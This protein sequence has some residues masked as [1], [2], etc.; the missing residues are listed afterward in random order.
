ML[1]TMKN[2]SV[3]ATP[4]V[5]SFRPQLEALEDRVLMSA[6]DALFTTYHQLF[7]GTPS[8]NTLIKDF[9]NAGVGGLTVVNSPAYV[10]SRVYFT[11][12]STNHS[13]GTQDNQLWVS[14]GTSAGTREVH[15]FGTGTIGENSSG[16]IDTAPIG[17]KIGF[18]LTPGAYGA[19]VQL[20]ISNGTSVGTYMVE[21]FP[22]ATMALQ[23]S[24]GSQLYFTVTST[25]P[26]GFDQYY[27][28]QLLITDGTYADTFPLDKAFGPGN[29]TMYGFTA[30]GGVL[31]YFEIG[32]TKGA[33]PELIVTNGTPGGTD[34]VFSSPDFANI[35]NAVA[36]GYDLYFEAR[37]QPL[38]NYP[39]TFFNEL[40]VSHDN[41][42]VETTMLKNFGTSTFGNMVAAGNQVYF[43]V[44]VP[45]SSSTNDGYLWTATLSGATEVANP[46]YG[47]MAAVGN[48]L[49]FI[50]VTPGDA[51]LYVSSGTPSTTNPVFDFG[52]AVTS[53]LAEIPIVLG[54]GSQEYTFIVSVGSTNE[55]K[56]YTSNGTSAGTVLLANLGAGFPS[57]PEVLSS[58]S[59]LYFPAEYFVSE[60]IR[61]YTS[62]GTP[63][64]T[65][66]R[67]VPGA[68]PDV[69]PP[70]EMVSILPVPGQAPAIT[71]GNSAT[72]TV[73]QGGSFTVTATGS[74][75]PTLSESGALPNG[76]TFTNNGNGTA[77]LGGTPAAGTQ[78]VY[79]FTILSH[80]GVGSDAVQ[81]FILTVNPAL[82]P[83][84]PPP[85]PAQPIMPP[86][87]ALFNQFLGGL[88]TV[89]ANGTTIT[90]N[91]FG[92]P[93]VETYDYFGNLVSVTL[94]GFDVTFL[95][96]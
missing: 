3:K 88:E 89:N 58:G 49:Y 25:T 51:Q 19:D 43:I 37:W 86:L 12:S 53:N 67:D 1:H 92:F 63:T 80:N 6:G 46:N 84:P 23:K 10:G 78:G 40:W 24:I 93:M 91:L 61:L 2:L 77:S 66:Y 28:T 9:G 79:H 75:T 90:D 85:P 87:L 30:V 41:S 20:W 8:G 45:I 69:A 56:L 21:D 15:D 50:S 68:S 14:D 36:I 39:G 5:Q 35:V 13:N 96:G 71:S 7:L 16:K 57:Y 54:I 11:V 62:D 26:E 17:D 70:L 4:K 29:T 55:Y 64:G 31:D 18:A 73:G 34:E 94:L 38:P 59:Q 83:P 42:S 72:F 52:N 32:Q 74:P 44:S 95:F 60:D 76:V 22:K 65:T 47:V 82:A 81:S 48:Q 27:E 33:N